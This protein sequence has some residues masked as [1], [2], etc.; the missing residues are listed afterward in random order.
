MLSSVGYRKCHSS[1]DRRRHQ[2]C[3]KRGEVSMFRTVLLGAA[4]IAASAAM[5]EPKPVGNRVEVNGMQMYYEVSGHGDPLIVLHGA[6]MNIPSMGAIIPKLAETHKVYAARAAGSRPH[7]GHRPAHHLSRPGRR[8]GG[9]HGRRGSRESGRVRLLDGFRR[10]AAARHPS[11]RQ[12]E[13]ARCSFRRLRRRG[14]AARVQGHH[15]ADERG[16][17]GGYARSQKDIASSRPIPTAF[18]S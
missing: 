7:H 16:D 8:R 18:P 2:P 4:L 12:G 5:A 10:R 17:D 9:V 11:P 1:N 15:P 14:L 3:R 13:Q 6:Y